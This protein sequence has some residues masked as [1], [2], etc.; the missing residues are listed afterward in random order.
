MGEPGNNGPMGPPGMGSSASLV[1]AS[2]FD[3]MIGKLDHILSQMIISSKVLAESP[4]L[5]SEVQRQTLKH[6]AEDMI[7]AGQKVLSNLNPNV[8]EGPSSNEAATVSNAERVDKLDPSQLE[9]LRRDL[10]ILRAVRTRL[11]EFAG[12]Y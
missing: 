12:S 2:S 1:S 4:Y 10:R 3:L 8:A 6:H 7:G 9:Q 11:D 5:E